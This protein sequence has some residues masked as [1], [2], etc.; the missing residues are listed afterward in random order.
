M[1]LAALCVCLCGLLL[2]ASVSAQDGALLI[3]RHA[4]FDEVDG[5][6]YGELFV[7]D[8]AG[9]VV[10]SGTPSGG[11]EAGQPA[12]VAP[13]SYFVE[14]GR[15]RTGWGIA[16]VEVEAGVTTVVPTG[17]VTLA[18]TPLSEQPSLGCNPWNAEFSAFEQADDGREV[19]AHTN[20]GTGVSDYG[21][22]QLLEGTRRV[23]FN[24]LPVDVSVTADARQ[25]LPVG[26]QD[27][28]AGDRP[29]IAR[30]AGD[31][32]G[33][34][35]IPLCEDGALQVPAGTYQA[36]AIV[37]IETHPYERR[38]WTEVQVPNE[39]PEDPQALSTPRIDGD[40]R[41]GVL[42]PPGDADAA[43]LGR[44][45]GTDGGGARRLSGFGR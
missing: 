40:V 39:S 16:K 6:A 10:P 17:W 29:V 28:I 21:A 8:S 34:V 23:Y 37:P 7:Y 2:P 36:S 27:P 1:R 43:A 15:Y 12:T 25:A 44:I 35:R 32:E 45:R 9:A 41:A 19:V 22:M 13:G 11:F 5:A 38:E 33:N 20:R 30:E 26:F 3:H 42:V 18:T 31:V 14:V 24:G 4:A